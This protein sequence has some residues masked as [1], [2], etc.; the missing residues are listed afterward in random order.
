MLSATAALRILNYVT[1][2]GVERFATKHGHLHRYVTFPEK[3]LGRKLQ[4]LRL[5]CEEYKG[6][7]ARDVGPLVFL[8]GPPGPAN[9]FEGTLLTFFVDLL[10]NSWHAKKIRDD[11]NN[12]KV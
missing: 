4:T 6:V 7:K 11:A 10:L 2:E 3:P 5:V 9:R 12:I 8:G 1:V